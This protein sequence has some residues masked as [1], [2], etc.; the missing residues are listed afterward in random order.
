MDPTLVARM[1]SMEQRIQDL[2]GQVEDLK[3]SRRLENDIADNTIDSGDTAWM[4]VA[5]ALVLF[6]TVPGQ[7]IFYAGMVRTENVLATAMEVFSIT[8][9]AIVIWHSVGYTLAFGPVDSSTHSGPIIGDLSRAFLWGM[10]LDSTHQIAPSIPESI[11]C[12]YQLTFIIA[13]PVLMCGS[14][15]ERM[16]YFPCLI[17]MGCWMLIVYCPVAHSVWH[18]DGWLAKMGVMDTAGGIVCHLN[19]GIASLMCVKVIGNRR[20]QDNNLKT[21]SEPHNVLFTIIGCCMMWVS[22][23]GFNAGG[24]YKSNG[25][26]CNIIL[27]TI[28][29]AAVSA[30]SWMVVEWTHRGRPS[31]LGMVNGGVAGLV[32]VTPACGYV[33][34]GGSFVIGLLGGVLVFYGTWIKQAFGFD[35]AIDA[36][37]VNTVGGIVGTTLTGIFA[38]AAVG[39][40]DG[41]FFSALKGEWKEGMFRVGVQLLG[42]LATGLWSGVVSLIVLEIIDKTIGLRVSA[43]DERMGLDEALH[44]EHLVADARQKSIMDVINYG[45]TMDDNSVSS[46]SKLSRVSSEDTILSLAP[47]EVRYKEHHHHSGEATPLMVFDDS[48]HGFVY[49]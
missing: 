43:K 24:A 18:P 22:W 19:A 30:W 15:S 14:F 8:C 26:S 10:T 37:G 29:G 16:K 6:M 12:A 7:A 23:L 13:A 9:L 48:V 3:G 39:G 36:F 41:L 4:I 34:P 46:V 42:L 32:C 44:H 35:D 33:T 27:N 5:T 38:T 31:V 17:F 21:H 20:L 2:L 28:V 47:G 40:T 49:E 25:L 11:F 45:A 1:A